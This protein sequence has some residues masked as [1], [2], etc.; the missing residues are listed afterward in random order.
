MYENCCKDSGS[1]GVDGVSYIVGGGGGVSYIG[2]VGVAYTSSAWGGGGYSGGDFGGGG[3][4]CGGDFGGGGGDC[5][6]GC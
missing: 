1:G 6:G 2:D 3:G 5:G 4:Y